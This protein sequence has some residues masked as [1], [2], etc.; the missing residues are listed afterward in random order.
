MSRTLISTMALAM[1]LAG[2]GCF[3]V[4][5]G[6]GIDGAPYF[7]PTP[8]DTGRVTSALTVSQGEQSGEMGAIRDFT[9]AARDLSGSYD[10]SYSNVRLDSV[11]SGWWVMSAINISGDL[12]G[13]AFAPGTRRTFTSGVWEG[14]EPTVSVTGCS[15]P[16][17]GNYTFDGPSQNVE[18]AVEALPGSARR[19]HYVATFSDGTTTT[20]SFDYR[21]EATGGRVAGGI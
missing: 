18:I 20:G 3:T 15:G 14:D 8:D 19:M 10:P 13:P 7:P 5:E 2:A 11:G 17:Y 4:P 21:I 12:A 6:P 16:E 9:G 1:A